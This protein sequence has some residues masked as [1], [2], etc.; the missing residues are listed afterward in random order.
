MLFFHTRQER[1]LP[2][3]M[4]STRARVL[5]S[6][7]YTGACTLE[8]PNERRPSIHRTASIRRGAPRD[9]YPAKHSP[10]VSGMRAIGFS[11]GRRHCFPPP[12]GLCH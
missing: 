6:L 7:P 8:T 9:D 12:D 1:H 2:L 5:P 3:V 4:S 11:A 10:I